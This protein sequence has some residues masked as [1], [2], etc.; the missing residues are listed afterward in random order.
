M[1]NPD[2]IDLTEKEQPKE[3]KFPIIL[4]TQVPD[5]CAVCGSQSRIDSMDVD[6]RHN[7]A[8]SCRNCQA[9][10]QLVNRDWALIAAAES[11]GDLAEYVT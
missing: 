7:A 2:L 11:G 8:F 9:K 10:V 4:V 1:P 6:F 5:F 3:K